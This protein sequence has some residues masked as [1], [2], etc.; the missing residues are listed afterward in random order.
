MARVIA[1]YSTPADPAAFDAYYFQHHVPLAK[2]MPGLL[3]YEI[4]SGPVASP[5]SS[6]GVHLVAILHFASMA[7]I[8]E[9]LGSPQGQ[10]TARD[11]A[12]F[13]SGGVD[14]LMMDSREL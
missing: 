10:A 1:I 12:N 2:T 7:A 4:S 13:A 3:K 14:L 9:A 11:L 6:K 5:A 8:N